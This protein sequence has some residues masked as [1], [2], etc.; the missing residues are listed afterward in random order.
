[1][2]LNKVI[3]ANP[4][5]IF[6]LSFLIVLLIYSLGWSTLYPA[7]SSSVLLFLFVFFVY[8]IFLGIKMHKFCVPN[9]KYIH[10]SKLSS[11]MLLFFYLGWILVFI[12]NRGIPLLQLINDPTGGMAEKAYIPTFYVVIYSFS[13]FFTTFTF[14]NYIFSKKK[15]FLFHFIFSL[16]PQILMVSRIGLVCS[17]IS[18]LFIYLYSLQKLR[19]KVLFGAS[20]FILLA[21]YLFGIIGNLRSVVFQGDGLAQGTNATTSFLESPIPNEY[22]WTYIYGASPLANFQNIVLKTSVP[23][24]KLDFKTFSVYYYLPDFITNRLEEVLQVEKPYPENKFIIPFL[25]VSTIYTTSYLTLG[26]LGPY[27][28]LFSYSL[29]LIM[30]ILILNKKSPYFL[31]GIAIISTIFFLSIFDNILTF[32][33]ISF[34]LIYPILLNFIGKIRSPKSDRALVVK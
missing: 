2:K 22:Y 24:T 3:F 14:Q 23:I 12:Y 13:C 4:F 30:Y 16:L 25:N 31:T 1:M 5:L 15:H 10:I 29:F 33:A 34:Q 18:V 6:A 8:N 17:L 7:L 32:S 27:L 26:W 28:I 19:K 21:L 9:L 20:L 11:R